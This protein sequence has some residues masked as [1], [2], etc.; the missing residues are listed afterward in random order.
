M[1]TRVMTSTLNATMMKARGTIHG[2]FVISNA[3]WMK[4]KIPQ[5]TE[6]MHHDAH[7]LGACRFGNAK[8]S[9]ST[10]KANGSISAR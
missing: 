9:R 10:K 4:A 6:K 2:F 3:G 8:S 7:D 5:I 1:V